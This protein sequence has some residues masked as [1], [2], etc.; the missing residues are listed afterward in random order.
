M[1]YSSAEKACGFEPGN[2]A[3]N[4]G[5]ERAVVGAALDDPPFFGRA[6]FPP[7][8]EKPPGEQLAEQRADA[9][10]GE[11]IPAAPDLAGFPRVVAELRFVERRGHEIGEAHAG[12]LA[13]SVR[14][15][16]PPTKEL[17]EALPSDSL[18]PV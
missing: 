17:R 6:G 3:E 1:A 12:R 8:A 14:V 11:K 5:G 15:E 13:G 18:P 16:W 9:H 7:L 10:A 4:I 2:R